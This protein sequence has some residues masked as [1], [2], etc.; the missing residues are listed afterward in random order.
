M[1]PTRLFC[2][3][4][5]VFVLSLAAF[6]VLAQEHGAHHGAAEPA[7][8]GAVPQGGG[9]MMMPQGGAMGGGGMMPGMAGK[10]MMCPCPM[11]PMGGG[12]M[13]GGGMMG[14]MGPA[15]ETLDMMAVATKDM[16]QRLRSGKLSAEETKAMGQ[17]LERMS[18]MLGEMT[19]MM[20]PQQ[21][22]TRLR[23]QMEQL[24][25]QMGLT[26]PAR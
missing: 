21:E 12:P 24:M 22:M 2:A 14:L 11:C 15:T 8:S 6:P 7:P 25:G 9:C 5:L 13:G 4:A 16:A 3:L 10:G 1:R 26:P 17:R 19:E 20:K 23:G 18:E